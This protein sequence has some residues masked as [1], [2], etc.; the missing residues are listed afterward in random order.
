[1]ARLPPPK[2]GRFQSRQLPERRDN[3]DPR[4]FRAVDKIF[5][6]TFQQIVD[7]LTAQQSDR[8][9]LRQSPQGTYDRELCIVVNLSSAGRLRVCSK[10]HSAASL[11]RLRDEIELEVFRHDRG[12]GCLLRGMPEVLRVTE[13]ERDG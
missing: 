4:R 9:S 2:Y 7:A 6:L 13:G 1:M 5:F 10:T 3:S 8:H 12:L 11:R